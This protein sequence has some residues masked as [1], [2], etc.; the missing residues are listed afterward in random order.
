[1]NPYPWLMTPAAARAWRPQR[2]RR[3]L[4]TFRGACGHCGYD[5][6]G[7]RKTCPACLVPWER[8]DAA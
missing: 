4:K 1:M 8:S 3:S 7:Y 5:P 2:R 6:V